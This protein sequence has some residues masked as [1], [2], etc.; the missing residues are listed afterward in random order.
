MTAGLQMAEEMAQQTE[1]VRAL[2]ARRCSLVPRI[3]SVIPCEKARFVIV[4]RGSSDNTSVFARYVLEHAARTPVTITAPSLQTRYDLPTDY[5]G[6]VAVAVSQSG[7]T[8]EIVTTL[9]RMKAKGA[10]GV[11]IT[12]NTDSPL[13]A[14]ADLV[15]ELGAG[16]ELAV[17]ATK[18]VT[19]TLVAFALLAEAVGSVPWGTSDWARLVDDVERVLADPAAMVAVAEQLA[20]D[21]EL[22]IAARGYLYAAALETALKIKET[23]GM[24]AQG[25]SA[26]EFRHGP[27]G[28]VRDGFP[29][30]AM[31]VPG[32]CHE[33]VLAL[34]A[35]VR[36]RG[37][38]ALEVPLENVT[39]PEALAVVPATVRGQQ[40]AAA[41]ATARGLDADHP[42][43]LSK[44]TSTV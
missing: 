15:V 44:V 36:E 17:P 27:I 19:A 23:T 1:V 4:A 38:R 32:P 41:L 37:G 14:A 6:V 2:V 13:A 24:F 8:P 28:M 26:A 31:T 12:N 33:D 42:D 22:V 9:E 3:R 10:I 21:R 25:Y 43:G 5:G 29:L 20:D 39:V 16:E 7:L 35:A 40:V 11:A 34:A 18:T 30:L